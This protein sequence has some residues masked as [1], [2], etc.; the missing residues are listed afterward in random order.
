[1]KEDGSDGNTV[2]DGLAADIVQNIYSPWGG[3]RGLIDRFYTLMKVP[4]DSTLIRIRDEDGVDGYHFMSPDEIDRESTDGTARPGPLRWNTLPV[5][6]AGVSSLIQ[7][8]VAVND[9][10]GR[11]WL[12]GR[13]YVDL[14]DS[15]LGALKTECEILHTLTLSLKGKI[16]SRFALA[17]LWYVPSEITNVV[18][19]GKQGNKTMDVLDY[20]SRA[21]SANVT[22]YETA[23]VVL[24][25]LLRG[26]GAFAD[27]LK[28]INIDASLLDADLKLRG[29]LID[30]ILF[31]L[32]IQTGAVKGTETANHWGAWAMSDEEVRIAVQPDLDILTWALTR[33]ILH[34]QLEDAGMAPDQ[35]L[36]VRVAWD[37][38]ESAVRTNKQ[39]DT[40][41]AHDLGIANQASVARVT[42]LTDTDLM[43]EDEIIRWVG[44][45]TKNPPLM[46]HGI[47]VPPEE[48]EDAKTWGKSPGPAPDSPT[49]DSSVGPGV[50]DPGSPGGGDT[51]KDER[52]E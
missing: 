30:E 11:V 38:S 43:D 41:Q 50:G 2:T 28:I 6:S 23:E 34:P 17:G 49:E 15:A 45:L 10:L 36:K 44:R 19:A 8:E 1:M 31:G 22:N 14:P 18:V 25:I 48:W 9:V 40:R 46:L 35:I 12:P 52:P 33:L 27:Q 42:G 13:R 7:R 5:S 24:P 29:Q 21:L 26:P 20:L 16:R 3:V 47:E 32:D 37:V 39:E 4:A 51:D